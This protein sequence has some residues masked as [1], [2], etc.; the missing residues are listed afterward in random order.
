M[1][2]ERKKCSEIMEEANVLLKSV[3][4]WNSRMD[5]VVTKL[6][7]LSSQ[8]FHTLDEIKK[9][10]ELEAEIDSLNR[11]LDLEYAQIEKMETKIEK[12]LALNE[13][14]KKSIKKESTKKNKK[15]NKKKSK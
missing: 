8:K 6:E 15:K 14:S 4:H 12:Q 11:R 7:T 3:E 13:E 1:K 2:E 10:E 9:M 5:S